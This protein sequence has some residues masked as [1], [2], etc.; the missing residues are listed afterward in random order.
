MIRKLNAFAWCLAG[1]LAVSSWCL[2]G[3]EKEGGHKTAHGGCLNVIEKCAIGHMEVILEGDT[4]KVWFVGGDNATT[5]SVRVKA[6]EIPLLVTTDG[7]E[8]V[9]PL[10]LTAKP[11]ALAEETVGDCSHF[12]A[13]APW[14]K[15]AES[16]VAVGVVRV[17]GVLRV[18]RID[19]PEGFDPDDDHDH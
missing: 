2:A 13:S 19:Y 17:K 1:L 18:L 16:F 14:L 5:T 11:L 10:T 12:T 3:E 7:G 15:D 9:R 8:T 4:L 6:K